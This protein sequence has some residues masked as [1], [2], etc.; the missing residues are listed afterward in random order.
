MEVTSQLETFTQQQEPVFR[1]RITNSSGNYVE[2]T[3]WGARWITAMLPDVKG[4]LSN[5]IQGY[6]KLD[7]YLTD[8]YYMGAI[9]GRFANRIG[10]ASFNIDEVTYQLE[11]NDGRVDQWCLDQSGQLAQG[12]E[13]LRRNHARPPAGGDLGQQRG[14][15]VAFDA[16]LGGAPVGGQDIVQQLAAAHGRIQ[17]AQRQ[18]EHLVHRGR[19]PGALEHALLGDEHMFLAVQR[20]REQP[21]Q[22]RRVRV[23]QP[24]IELE[25]AHPGNDVRGAQAALDLDAGLRVGA[26]EGIGQSRH[27]GGGGGY[28]T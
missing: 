22:L 23:D 4:K 3:N 12:R 20:H 18:R 8:T 25:G 7:D 15:G 26:G 11:T 27:R 14:H 9:I 1:F 24:G 2:L 10:G 6:E 21:A 13:P 28:H 16:R 19:L 17:Q 5:V